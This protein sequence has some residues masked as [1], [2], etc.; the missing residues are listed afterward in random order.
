[1]GKFEGIKVSPG[2]GSLALTYPGAG[3]SFSLFHAPV[4]DME[5]AIR[6]AATPSSSSPTKRAGELRGWSFFPMPDAEKDDPP[7]S[8]S[9]T[10]CLPPSHPIRI[11][12]GVTAL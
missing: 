11:G 8:S 10:L 1:M 2:D 3:P 9:P 7:F 4:K 12:F 6:L 5:H